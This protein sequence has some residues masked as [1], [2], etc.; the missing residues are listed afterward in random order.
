MPM[1]MDNAAMVTEPFSA[2]PPRRK[3]RWFQFSLRSPLIFTLVCAIP[4]NLATVFNAGR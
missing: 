3:R 1:P 2:V 4:T